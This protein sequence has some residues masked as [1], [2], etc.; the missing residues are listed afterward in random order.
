MDDTIDPDEQE[1]LKRPEVGKRN[2]PADW[3]CEDELLF[4]VIQDTSSACDGERDTYAEVDED[5]CGEEDWED[6]D[7]HRRSTVRA[8]ATMDPNWPPSL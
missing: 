2:N 5:F 1:G 7:E 6:E 4:N 8:L 3:I